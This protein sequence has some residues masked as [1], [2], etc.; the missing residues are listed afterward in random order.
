MVADFD[1][2]AP[3]GPRRIRFEDL[4]TATFGCVVACWEK[5]WLDRFDLAMVSAG[6]SR[7]YM[8]DLVVFSLWMLLAA[9]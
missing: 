4:S 7:L 8:I 1:A 6:I 2:S 3:S 5:A 9:G